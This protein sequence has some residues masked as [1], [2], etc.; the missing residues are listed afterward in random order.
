VSP[1]NTPVAVF[2]SVTV[3]DVVDE[4]YVPAGIA[5]VVVKSTASMVV[6]TFVVAANVNTVPDACAAIVL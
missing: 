6:L 2:E 3:V 1:L 5:D 4:T